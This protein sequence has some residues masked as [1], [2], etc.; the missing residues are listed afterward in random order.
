VHELEHRYRAVG[1]RDLTAHYYPEARHEL[2]NETNRDQVQQDIAA[3][4]ERIT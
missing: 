1:L 4:L 3:W 2:L